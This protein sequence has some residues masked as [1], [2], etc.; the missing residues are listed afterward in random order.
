MVVRE[1]LRRNERRTRKRMRI[2]V[3][4]AH[5]MRDGYGARIASHFQSL[6][7]Q[8]ATIKACKLNQDSNRADRQTST[9]AHNLTK[10]L[11]YTTSTSHSPQRHFNSMPHS[12][13]Q[14]FPKH[15]GIE[16][17]NHTQTAPGTPHTY[18]TTNPRNRNT[19]HQQSPIS[20]DSRQVSTCYTNCQVSR[21]HPCHVDV[22]HFSSIRFLPSQQ[23]FA[24]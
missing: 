16:T 19:V 10:P 18:R 17:F 15:G 6:Q 5:R 7:W 3:S 24:T 8:R 9:P 22:S 13:T 2:R 11:N 23:S 20:S 4:T 1:G 21:I 14:E 12:R